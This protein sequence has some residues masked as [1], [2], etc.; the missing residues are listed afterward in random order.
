MHGLRRDKW[1]GNAHD[2]NQE[3]KQ[4]K[5]R[6]Y[7]MTSAELKLLRLRLTFLSPGWPVF[8]EAGTTTVDA[9]FV[10]HVSHSTPCGSLST[11]FA[12]AFDVMFTSLSVDAW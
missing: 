5:P 2:E 10:I 6:T 4:E 11:F 3:K 8:F 9:L 7:T 12:L 1:V